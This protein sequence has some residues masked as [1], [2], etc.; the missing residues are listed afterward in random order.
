MT[1][2]LTVEQTDYAFPLNI[3]NVALGAAV[4]M[5]L[6]R[7]AP[8]EVDWFLERA[9]RNTGL[10]D[11]GDMRF[12]EGMEVLFDNIQRTDFSPLAREVLKGTHMQG[13]TNRLHLQEHLRRHPGVLDTKIERPVFVLGFPRTGTTLLQ[14][15]LSLDPQ[16]RG[17]F[18]WELYTSA[19]LHDDPARDEAARRRIA[20][21]TLMFANLFA[22]E[23]REVHDIRVD[24]Y[25]E[26]WYLFWNSMRVLNWD[27]QTGFHEYGKWLM[28]DA[29]MVQAYEEYRTWL[30]LSVSRMPVDHLVLKC[31]EHLWFID[32]LLEVFPDACIVWTHRDPVAS[33]ASYCSLMSLTRRT[34]FG[35]FVPTDMGPYVTDRFHEGVTRAMEARDRWGN[36]ATFYD[37][38]FDDL[39]ADPTGVVRGISDHFGLNWSDDMPDLIAAYEDSDREDKRGRHRY[40][41]EAFG[42]DPD[43][44]HELFQ[45]YVDRFGIRTRTA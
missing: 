41:P 33:V 39:V 2:S 13:L 27:I 35:K 24:T 21:T 22:P 26:C 3:A 31:P 30:Q 15:L 44:V 38:D 11:F 7:H 36:E 25:E 9:R 12:T 23:M 32:D 17:L 45:P 10:D 40:S 29:D 5:G 6:F 42:V 16:R 43:H 8:L 20:K 4:R 34:I 18:F 14:N 37:V 1:D 19:P 28:S